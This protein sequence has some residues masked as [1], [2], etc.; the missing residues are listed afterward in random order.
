[1][2]TE[3]TSKKREI[4][5]VWQR[6]KEI[7]S[8]IRFHWWLF[9]SVGPVVLIQSDIRINKTGESV[10]ASAS[11][12][13]LQ[14]N[15]SKSM[16]KDL[17]RR[18]PMKY[19]TVL[20]VWGF[21]GFQPVDL[22]P[23][24]ASWKSLIFSQYHL[25]QLAQPL[26]PTSMSLW[27]NPGLGSSLQLCRASS[28]CRP[29]AAA[30][31]QKQSVVCSRLLF[32]RETRSSLPCVPKFCLDKSSEHLKWILKILKGISILVRKHPAVF[33]FPA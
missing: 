33:L 21:S 26:D 16:H 1:M 29:V 31:L 28:G 10:L 9:E 19:C 5:V 18:T 20:L 17:M 4:S 14:C 2:W 8:K 11:G 13:L 24:S 6:W 7:V 12:L 15:C 23:P 3:L 27:G 32:S 22:L 25:P 30:A